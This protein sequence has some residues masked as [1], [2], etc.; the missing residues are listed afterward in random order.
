MKTVTALRHSQSPRY[1]EDVRTIHDAWRGSPF[2][3][4]CCRLN[5]SSIKKHKKSALLL[6]LTLNCFTV[7]GLTPSNSGQVVKSLVVVI[8]LILRKMQHRHHLAVKYHP[9][10]DVKRGSRE[11]K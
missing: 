11:I 6:P 8:L 5:F 4:H 7:S 1:Q 2:R 3:A 10:L 9:V